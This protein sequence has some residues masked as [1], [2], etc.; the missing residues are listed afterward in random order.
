[1]VLLS[2]LDHY[3]RREPGQT[4]VAGALLGIVS[5]HGEVE[6]RNSFAVPMVERDEGELELDYDFYKTMYDL[7]QR[8]NSKEVTIGWYA[9]GT[10]VSA[11]DY[12]THEY[13]AAQVRT[14]AKDLAHPIHLTVDTSLQGDRL[15]FRAYTRCAAERAL[16]KSGT[17][18]N[19]V[20]RWQL[21]CGRGRRCSRPPV[22]A[23][24]VRGSRLA[25]RKGGQY[26]PRM[27]AR[28]AVDA[29]L[30]FMTRQ[31]ISCCAPARPRITPSRS[32]PTSIPLRR[33]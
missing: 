13:F 2:I 30:T 14:T 8:V 19:C 29:E 26:V 24:A 10:T 12:G 27:R 7:H 16:L 22:H 6:I 33:P 9:T 23:G 18:I 3:L 25:Q 28:F 31:S 1:M 5:E 17:L 11:D 21:A 32:S 20:V 15:G 4:R